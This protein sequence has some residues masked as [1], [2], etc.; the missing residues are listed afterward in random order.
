[1]NKS[2]NDS[3]HIVEEYPVG[4]IFGEEE[5]EAIRRVLESGEPLTRGPDVELFEKEFAAYCGA[6][7]AVAVSSCGAAL[8][9]S[10][11]ILNLGPNDQVI[12]QANAFWVTINHLLERNVEIICADIDPESLNINPNIIE[13]LTTKRT[14]AIYLVHHGGNPA[15]LDAIRKIADKFGLVIVE[16]C[17]HAVGAEYKGSKIGS[18]S[19]IA[20]FSFSTLKN[21]STL[22]EGGMF[23]TNNESYAKLA[24][25]F[26]TNF[27]HGIREKRK[28]ADLGDYP[29]PRSVAFM[30]M[31]DAWDYNW[32]RLD[33]MGSTYRLSTPQAAVGRIQLKK[34]DSLIKRRENIANRYNQIVNEIDGL[35]TVKILPECKHAWQL[36]TYFLNHETGIDRN[37]FV[38]QMADK[39]NIHIVIRY[40]PIHLGAIMRMQGCKLRARNGLENV[41]H[42]WF[43]EQLSLPIS[44]QMNDNEIEYIQDAIRDTMI[45]IS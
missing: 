40:F 26:R 35:R 38:K 27:P 6:K 14:K 43:K 28:T 7:Y 20:C 13:P 23:V 42:V 24:R 19:D 33:E 4:T 45:N 34:L 1:M 5:I 9:I 22:G 3:P 44:P 25:G 18:N 31:G 30:H 17:A 41:E 21:I 15:N 2:D 16:D 29:K 39:Y 10:S 37:K 12:C 11:K 36:Y 32:M 8:N